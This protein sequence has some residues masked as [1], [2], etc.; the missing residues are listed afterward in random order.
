MSDQATG[1]CQMAQDRLKHAALVDVARAELHRRRG[2]FEEARTAVDRALATDQ[3]CTAALIEEARLREARGESAEAL[4]AWDRA[5]KAWP[6]CYLCAVEA[7]RLTES[8][9]GKEAAVPLWEAALALQPDSPEALKRYGAA[10]A[11]LDDG[12]A[13]Q[14]YERA[15]AAG[16]ADVATLMGAAILARGDVDKSL[17]FA[18]RAVQA[19]PNDI[20]AWRHVLALAQQKSDG[21]KVAAAAG[22]LLRL[23]PDDI[24]AR[25]ALA[26]DARSGDRLVDAVVH[27]DHV[28]RAMTAGRASNVA[29]EELKALQKEHAALLTELKVADKPA[30]GSANTVVAAVQRTVQGLFVERLKKSPAAKKGTL[31]GMIEVG[32]TV[33]E[34]GAVDEVEIL[35]DTL[36]DAP[37]TASVV[38]NLRRSTITGGAKRYSFQMDFQ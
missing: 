21:E 24:L 5:R 35:Q 4:A 23:L 10:L 29:A 37:V 30:R 28:A 33:S 6:R 25:A 22:E 26:R 8:A 1:R 17:S 11:G 31:R 2:A 20:D 19:Q 9:T 27:Y 7:A 14:A 36:G 15:I 18:E 38:A 16:Q 32:V 34:S 13:L 3:G 12:R